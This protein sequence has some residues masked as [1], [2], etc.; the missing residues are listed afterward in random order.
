[1]LFSR[2]PIV[3]V[4]YLSSLFCLTAST[5]LRPRV[6]QQNWKFPLK[7]VLWDNSCLQPVPNPPSGTAPTKSKVILGA[8]NGALELIADAKDRMEQTYQTLSVEDGPTTVQKLQVDQNDPAYVQYFKNDYG[9]D[10]LDRI[11]ETFNRMSAVTNQ[12]GQGLRP[13]GRDGQIA[14]TCNNNECK[15][16]GTAFTQES[17]LRATSTIINIC[18]LFFEFETFEDRKMWLKMT[19]EEWSKRAFEGKVPEGKMRS[20]SKMEF[21]GRGTNASKFRLQTAKVLVHELSHVVWI[22]NTNPF[23]KQIGGL[24]PPEVYGWFKA[25]E[26]AANQPNYNDDTYTRNAD[27]Y[28][29][30]AEYGW[31]VRA[32]RSSPRTALSGNGDPWPA[33]GDRQKPVQAAA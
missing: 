18:D 33:A 3:S 12:L 9:K 6:N 26:Y 32:L 19:Q 1:M 11:R 31:W 10:R 24:K 23:N 21:G 30:Y 25:A 20:L 15:E 13:A 27:S 17:D 7:A 28:A 16:K 14:F 8:L 4:L 29:W 2:L 5:A 22:G